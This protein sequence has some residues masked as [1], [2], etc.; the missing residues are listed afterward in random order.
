MRATTSEL[1]LN[2]FCG[3]RFIDRGK[4]IYFVIL[5]EAKNLSSIVSTRKQ[6]KERFFASLRMTE[7]RVFPQPVQP[8]RQISEKT[9]L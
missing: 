7:R 1:M 9:G 2:L 3:S 4:T 8:R 5:S 6:K